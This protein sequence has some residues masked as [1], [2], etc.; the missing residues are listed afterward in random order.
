VLCSLVSSR[1]AI[2]RP[3]QA[4]CISCRQDSPESELCEKQL[5]WLRERIELSFLV[6]NDP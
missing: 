1:Q 6:D 4:V 2:G 5:F 3:L